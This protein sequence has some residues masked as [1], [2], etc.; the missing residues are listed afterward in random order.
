M[1]KNQHIKRGD[2]IT[3]SIQALKKGPHQKIFLKNIDCSV[4]IFQIDNG[5]FLNIGIL[6]TIF[7]TYSYLKVFIVYLKFYR[8]SYSLP[9]SP[10]ERRGAVKAWWCL[11][12]GLWPWNEKWIDSGTPEEARGGNYAHEPRLLNH[13]AGDKCR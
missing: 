13:S 8:V 6:H 2:I 10:G 1:T 7:R 12:L 5:L 11:G 9:G 3:N 4:K